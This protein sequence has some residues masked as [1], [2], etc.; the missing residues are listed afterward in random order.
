MNANK[1]QLLISILRKNAARRGIPNRQQ[2]LRTSVEP[3][4]VKQTSKLVAST[5]QNSIEELSNPKEGHPRTI[6]K[7]KT[8]RPV[9]LTIEEI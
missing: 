8:V 7:S 1:Q 6:S 9:T 4:K 2:F 5:K 3:E